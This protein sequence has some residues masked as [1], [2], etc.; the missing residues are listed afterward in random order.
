LALLKRWISLLEHN[1]DYFRL[2]TD[3]KI[4]VPFQQMLIVAPNLDPERDMEPAFLRR[5]GYRV[6]M[7]GPG[8]ARYRGS[9][10]KPRASGGLQYR[11]AWWSGSSTVT[12][13]KYGNC[14][15]ANRT[16]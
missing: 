8:A 7:V 15:A 14:E 3:T 9:S 5:M 6:H 1:F 16:T 11:S 4:Q 2:L 12:G 13:R 10:R